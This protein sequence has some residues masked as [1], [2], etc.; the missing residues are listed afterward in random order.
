MVYGLKRKPTF[1][2]LAGMINNNPPRIKYPNRDATFL[3]KTPQMQQFLG[4]PSMEFLERQK[5]N[6]FKQ[7]LIT[8]TL[9]LDN[10]LSHDIDVRSEKS[11][12]I[13]SQ[14]RSTFG[15]V[16]SQSQIISPTNLLSQ[17]DNLA[18]PERPSAPPLTPESPAK[19]P[20]KLSPEQIE[21]L[22]PTVKSCC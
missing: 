7:E 11:Q 3:L 13:A 1:E 15:S 10:V 14:A 6:M 18:T 19:R 2:Q 20:L 4:E 8:N 22:T 12:S 9:S 17:F 16:Q 21:K 5:N